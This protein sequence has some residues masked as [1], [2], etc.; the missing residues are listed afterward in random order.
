MPC[1]VS[2]VAGARDTGLLE[3]LITHPASVLLV[4][5]SDEWQRIAALMPVVGHYEIASIVVMAYE[6]DVQILTRRPGLYV[7]LPD[8]GPIIEV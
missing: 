6:L 4:D 2:A 7:K 5:N 1:L 8:G 3:L